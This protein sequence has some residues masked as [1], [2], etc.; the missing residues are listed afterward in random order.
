MLL[1]H[2]TNSTITCVCDSSRILSEYLSCAS[3]G[4]QQHEHDRR[5]HQRPD[6]R[7]QVE[8][9]RY[10]HDREAHRARQRGV[11]VPQERRG[12]PLGALVLH[13]VEPEHLR[14]RPQQPA[15][16]V[17]V[18]RDGERDQ[19]QAGRDG[20]AQQGGQRDALVVQIIQ[21]VQAEQHGQLRPE[22]DDGRAGADDEPLDA[23]VQPVVDREQHERQ[24]HN[25]RQRA[26]HVEHKVE[27]GG[28]DQHEPDADRHAEPVQDRFLQPAPGEHDRAGERK[29]NCGEGQTESSGFRVGGKPGAAWRTPSPTCILHPK[30]VDLEQL[31]QRRDWRHQQRDEQRGQKGAWHHARELMVIVL[32][33]EILQ[34]LAYNGAPP[35]QSTH[36]GS[37]GGRADRGSPAG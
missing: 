30:L 17:A 36:L 15:P 14:L 18:H 27:L 28:G 26:A 9:E 10:E 13:R 16:E 29:P 20:D 1:K 37:S 34:Q 8:A 2:S 32:Q 12:A 21:Q 35:S 23:P 19:Q 31:E 33:R 25:V 11:D 6:A 5:H 22:D 7:L 4:E 3:E 24:R